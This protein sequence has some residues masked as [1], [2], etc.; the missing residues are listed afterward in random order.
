MLDD[1]FTAG[2]HLA[3]F[4]DFKYIE[5]PDVDSITDL[6]VTVYYV[7]ALGV[8]SSFFGVPIF[9]LDRNKIL[10][11]TVDFTKSGS[12]VISCTENTDTQEI[13]GTNFCYRG[14]CAANLNYLEVY[15][16]FF[17][18]VNISN[19]CKSLDHLLFY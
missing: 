10:V 7:D 8:P 3:I 11:T 5:S 2:A 9:S 12:N 1:T 4:T 19:R 16:Y 17:S 13:S 14:T 18:V 6:N 15:D